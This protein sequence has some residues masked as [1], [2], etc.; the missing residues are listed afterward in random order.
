[1]NSAIGLRLL[2]TLGHSS[3]R[4]VQIRTAQVAK[5]LDR[6]GLA[7]HSYERALAQDSPNRNLQLL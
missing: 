7:E 4:V 6:L 3:L 5:M 2:T 1:M